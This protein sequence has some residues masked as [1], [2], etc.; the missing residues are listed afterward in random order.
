MRFLLNSH[1]VPTTG[2]PVRKVQ[3]G[4]VWKQDASGDSYL[5]TKIYTEA[6][7]TVAVLRKTGSENQSVVRVKGQ[8]AD[9]GQTPP[10]F[11]S[12]QGDDH[13]RSPNPKNAQSHG[14]TTPRR[15]SA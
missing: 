9:P 12:E 6:L 13:L 4:Q 11:T 10:G 2:M 5:V 14:L 3:I 15:V 8:R 1:G 7:A